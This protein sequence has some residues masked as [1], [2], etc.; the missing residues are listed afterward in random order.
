VIIHSIVRSMRK[1]AASAVAVAALAWLGFVHSVEPVSAKQTRCQIKH[2]YCQERC[3]ANNKHH[4]EDSIS[5]AAACGSRTCDHQFRACARESGEP[6]DPNHG[7]DRPRG[8]PGKGGGKREAASSP[9]P[10]QSPHVLGGGILQ[11][12]GGFSQQGPAATGAPVS[13]PSAPAAPPVI[14]R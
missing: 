14:L 1:P 13:A 5:K 3:I 10:K 11:N 2:S 12:G 7:Y 8:K 6:S 4:S 9:A